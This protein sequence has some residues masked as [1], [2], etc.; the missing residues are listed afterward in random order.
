MHFHYVQNYTLKFGSFCDF[1]LG[2]GSD[3]CTT[4]WMIYPPVFC[5]NSD[6]ENFHFSWRTVGT[7]YVFEYLD[8]TF[9]ILSGC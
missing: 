6:R 7:G 2:R 9:W 3:V 4:S 8:Y 5:N 1:L